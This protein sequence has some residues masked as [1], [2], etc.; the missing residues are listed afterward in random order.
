[1]SGVSHR[2]SIPE[3]EH[4]VWET[5]LRPFYDF[6]VKHDL[7]DVLLD[8]EELARTLAF[9][10]RRTLFRLLAARGVDDVL[11]RLME[12]TGPVLRDLPIGTLA[13]RKP[14]V[15]RLILDLRRYFENKIDDS[16]LPSALDA[17][18]RSLDQF[19]QPPE[20]IPQTPPK[21]SRL[22]TTKEPSSE[23]TP[24]KYGTKNLT[25]EAETQNSVMDP[26]LAAELKR[27]LW[28]TTDDSFFD[29]YFPPVDDVPLPSTFPQSPT[30]DEVVKWFR[31]YYEEFCNHDTA[32]RD[33]V[34]KWQISPTRMPLHPDNLNR[35][36]DLFI[37][38]KSAPSN[39]PA[40]G[41]TERA[42]WEDVVVVGELK[43]QQNMGYLSPKMVIQIS[44]YV[45]E[46]FGT[47]PG[48]RFLHAF[49]ILSH[50]MRC[51][52]FT[53][54]GG[55]A[56]KSFELN[57]ENGLCDPGSHCQSRAL[58]CGECRRPAIWNG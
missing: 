4:A 34:W 32:Q 48:R 57:T 8:D 5:S 43:D 28:C 50:K 22:M 56:S 44:N 52:I 45:R 6:L 41:N 23:V 15:G 58:G 12:E 53:R 1:M 33:E 37:I 40:G 2:H 25:S 46:T 55:V 29:T 49:T 35:K 54:S 38:S 27:S 14:A 17:V 30:E 11:A 47:Q 24:M 13:N 16:A 10:L 36:I 21:G 51:W 7:I 39:K 26:K 31:Q 9:E 18:V 42:R 3:S 19:L 20:V